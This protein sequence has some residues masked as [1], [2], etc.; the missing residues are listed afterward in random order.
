MKRIYNQRFWSFGGWFAWVA[1]GA[2]AIS[3]A[4]SV[5]SS[6][7]NKAQGSPAVQYTPVDLQQTQSQAI[8]GDQSS[9]SSLDALLGQSN[10]FQQ[11]QAT[12]LM[13]QALPGYS[14]FAQNLTNTASAQ[15][16]N[17]YAIPQSVVGQLSQYAAENNINE[18]TGAASGFS[19]S[20]LLRS[21][22]VNALQYG[23]SNLASAQNSLSVLSNTAP[24]ISPMSPMSFMVTPQQQ[25]ANQTLTNSN[26]QAINQG[27]ANSATAA[28]NA[29]SASLWDSISSGTGQ[30]S[31][32]IM[33]ALMGQNG[34][35]TS[36]ASGQLSYS[37]FL[38]NNPNSSAAIGQTG[39][40]LA[41]G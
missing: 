40:A 24:K 23:Q 4:G 28:G 35:Q 33:Q 9:A 34:A 37:Q 19:S 12:G 39:S 20:N 31:G 21:L 32:P 17:P 3:T 38:A 14:G 5:Y 41:G 30:L 7:Q 1:L 8:A 16:A 29:N 6:S 25:A 2:A 36:G 26:N 10:S 15:A 13:N 27:A 22:G 11:Q 18:G